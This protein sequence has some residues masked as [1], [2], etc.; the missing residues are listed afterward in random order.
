M[1]SMFSYQKCNWKKLLETPTLFL[2]WQLKKKCQSLKIKNLK[3]SKRRSATGDHAGGEIVLS[4]RPLDCYKLCTPKVTSVSTWQQQVRW[5]VRH[6]R[7]RSIFFHRLGQTR[8]DR[9][10]GG[11]LFSPLLFCCL[12]GMTNIWKVWK[13]IFWLMKD[14]N[15]STFCNS[16]YIRFF[17][18]A[19]Q[20]ITT[21]RF[22]YRTICDCTIFHHLGEDNSRCKISGKIV[23]NKRNN[24]QNMRAN[25]EVENK[26][27]G[28]GELAT[29]EPRELKLIIWGR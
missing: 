3:T 10:K 16:I 26:E 1:S 23:R 28:T 8:P 20:N 29:D 14:L 15:H 24:E 13:M 17:H 22:W 7:A 2:F 12:N 18:K 5:S 21:G 4:V 25:I 19:F 27:E 9:S 6:Q 11:Y